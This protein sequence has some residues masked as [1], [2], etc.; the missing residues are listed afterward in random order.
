MEYQVLVDI[1]VGVAAIVAGWIFKIV[2]AQLNEVKKEHSQLVIKQTEDYRKM[3]DKHVTLA[4]TLP[5]KYVSKSDFNQ[6]AER[7]NQRFDRLEEKIDDLKSDKMD[8]R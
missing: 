1:A 4:L 6:F 7:M 8:K 3:V 5:E 2:L